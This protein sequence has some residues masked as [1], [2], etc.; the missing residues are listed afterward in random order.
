LTARRRGAVSVGF[1]AFGILSGSWVP[2]LPAF[3]ER[4]HLTD[5]QVGYTLVAFAVGSIIGAALARAVLGRGARLYVR[6]GIAALG[7]ALV[8]PALAT[9]LLWLLAGFFLVGACNGF[10]DVLANA[11]AAEVERLAGRPLIN[12]FHGFWSLGAIMG[13]VAAG[14]AAYFG[15]AP[16]AQFALVAAFTVAGSAWSLGGLPDTRS[17]AARVAPAGAGRMWLTGSVVAVAAIAFCGLVVEGGSGDWS[18]LYLRELSHANPG[19]AAAGFVGLSVAAALTRFRADFLTARTSPATVARLGA[20]VAAAGLA[21]AVG[22]PALPG[23][24]AGF[25]LVGIGTAVLVPLAFAAGANLGAS[26]TAL[27]LVMSGGYAGSLVGPALIGNTADRF[28]LRVAMA[29]PFLAALAI[30]ALA[31]NLRPSQRSS[32]VRPAPVFRS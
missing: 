1:F 5:S 31:G 30:V 17:G 27:A 21:L 19:V 2:R 14:I 4:L 26:G 20:L 12:G 22:V 29:V 16:L 23:A 24:I 3:K 10:V 9:G 18:A 15:V 8:T 28:G 11:Q 7:V 25:F 32:E 6:I 13:S